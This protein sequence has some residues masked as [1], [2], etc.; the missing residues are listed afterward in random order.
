VLVTSNETDF[1]FGVND[2]V[3]A[4]GVRNYEYNDEFKVTLEPAA[5][6]KSMAVP[7][8]LKANVISTAA[9]AQYP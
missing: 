7:W 8:K 4:P 2:L 9:D 1:D 3:N 5:Y 6:A